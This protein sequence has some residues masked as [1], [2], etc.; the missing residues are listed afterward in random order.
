YQPAGAL[1]RVFLVLFARVDHARPVL[2][3][4]RVAA[5]LKSARERRRVSVASGDNSSRLEI[6]LWIRGPA[7]AESIV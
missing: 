7:A 1:I 4:R 2:A 6:G 3:G 5:L